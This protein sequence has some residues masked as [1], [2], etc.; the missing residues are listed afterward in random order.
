M[1]RLILSLV[2]F[3]IIGF[4]HRSAAQSAYLDISPN[5][6]N[7]SLSAGSTTFTVDA[8][9]GWNVTDDA[10]WLTAIKTDGSTITVTYDENTSTSERTASITA[11]GTGGVTETVTLTQAGVTPY[12]DIT[13]NSQD[14]CGSAS[15]TTFN[16]DA[17]VGWSVTD[18][19]D[20]L[21]A[22]KTDGSTITVTYDQNT[23]TSER[24][25]HITATGTG[26][27]SETVTVTQIP[28]PFI[29]VSPSNRDVNALSGSTT[30]SVNTLG[31][32]TVTDDATWLTATK[33]DDSTISVTYDQNTSTSGRTAKITVTETSGMIGP[34]EAT[35]TQAGATPYLDVSP[36]SQNVGVE[37]GSTTFSVSTN[38]EWSVTDDA[39]W[40][41]ANRTHG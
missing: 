3:T 28:S 39:D 37:A 1:K 34:A 5:N 35:V 26:G 24:T 7:V 33:S 6:Q 2:L 32:W 11:S 41:S 15:S 36:N 8:N 17:N 16:V 12:L 10:T 22:T 14:V 31:D 13:P 27:V 25:A 18:D 29:S 40:L 21:T 30:F 38:V 9:V 19:A 20:W 4:S 23:S